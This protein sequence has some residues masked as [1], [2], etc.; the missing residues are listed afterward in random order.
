MDRRLVQIARAT[1]RVAQGIEEES[2]VTDAVYLSDPA[3]P[4]LQVLPVG[5]LRMQGPAPASTGSMKMLLTAIGARTGVGARLAVGTRPVPQRSCRSALCHPKSA[6]AVAAASNAATSPIVPSERRNMI[7]RIAGNPR[8]DGSRSGN[9]ASKLASRR[10]NS[11]SSSQE[12]SR[13]GSKRFS[14]WSSVRMANTPR[15][16]RGRQVECAAHS[17]D[18]VTD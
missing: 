9:T 5:R 17:Q 12:G 1:S 3:H 13:N 4:C 10:P 14:N 2:V 15:A 18:I 16:S 8:P 6:A 7:A 11:R